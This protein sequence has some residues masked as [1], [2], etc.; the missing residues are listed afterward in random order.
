MSSRKHRLVRGI[1]V[2]VLL[3]SVLA[4][5]HVQASPGW[6][7][8]VKLIAADGVDND[9][10]GYSVSVY[11]DTLVAGAPTDDYLRG[12]AYV[13]ARDLGS[14]STWGQ[15]KKLLAPDG[16]GGPYG[17][18]F[19]RSVGIW[20]DTIVV[21]AVWDD[22]G[23]NSN[24][25]SAYVFNRNQDGTNNW[26]LVRKLVPSDGASGDFFGSSVAIYGDTVVV[27]AE[28]YPWS[29]TDTPCAYVFDRNKDGPNQWG[30]V[31]KLTASDGVSVYWFGSSVAISGDTVVVGAFGYNREGGA[32]YVFY[33]DLGGEDNW[34]ELKK[35]VAS[36]GGG[37][38]GYS[39]AISGDI[40]VAGAP[41]ARPGGYWH[42][43]G[44][45]YVFYRDHGGANNW[46]E[47]KKLTAADGAQWDSLGKSVAIDGDVVLAGAHRGAPGVAYTFARN[48]GGSDNWGQV[49]RVG[50]PD[51]A[52][53]DSFGFAVAMAG[54]T[55]VVGAYGMDSNRG[56]VYVG[57]YTSPPPP[58]C[59]E[60]PSGMVSWWPG[61]GNA[62]DIAGPNH[63][64]LY[65]GATF[66]PGKV[67]QAFVL[68]GVD[69]YVA[70]PTVGVPAGTDA[71]TLELW[72]RMDAVVAAEAFFAGY[73]AFYDAGSYRGYTF[74]L[75]ASGT[76][77][78]FSTM[79]VMLMGPSLDLGRW[80]H[81][82]VTCVRPV[83]SGSIVTLWLNGQTVAEY[84]WGLAHL[85]TTP[86]TTFYIGRIPGWPGD[87]RRLQGAVD[88]LTVYDRALSGDE[89]LATFIAGSHGKCSNEAPVVNA[90]P[91]VTANEGMAF[92]SEG[93][94]SDP[95]PDTWTATVD[96]G[97]GSG[98]QPLGLVD[99]SF[100]LSHVYADDGTYTVLVTVDDGQGGVGTDTATVAVLNVAPTIELSGDASVDEGS[101]YTLTLGPVTDPGADTVELYIVH[102]GDG[103]TN[104]YGSQ[105]NVQ[106][107]Y[108]DGDASHTIRVDLVDE[109]GTHVG[110]GT[111]SV[112]VLNVAPA[113]G[114]INAPVD[115]VQLGTEIVASAAFVD[116]GTLD[117]HTALW[118]WG[119]G[120]TSDGTVT[121][122]GGSG[123]V[124]GSHTY[125]VPGIY[126]LHLT[127]T[128]N[129]GASGTAEFH[130][131]V[132]YNPE[133]GFVTGGGWIKSPAGAYVADASLV[134]KANFG[135]VSKYQ[136]GATI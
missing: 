7:G 89:I 108:A 24:Q 29:P 37:Y 10:L 45:A 99:K 71:R 63:G 53:A 13:F 34:G 93:S 51:G 75:G 52:A 4:A 3:I 41:C 92:S 83:A 132:V 87:T 131:I 26:G 17:D 128:D 5:L 109:D 62:W 115:P 66:A 135:F 112:T 122:P 95:D 84:E 35:L 127:V 85:N 65:N 116:P 136:K 103:H 90:G 59:L 31:K 100:T 32:A 102:W 111:L 104:T 38:L 129:D 74:H 105:G 110:A 44:A 1:L 19:G 64:V 97:D 78:I 42:C 18:S 79:S 76:R 36:D 46:G 125:T 118:D 9:E 27:G 28:L 86:G 43:V 6:T 134:G 107:T 96:Y 23:S 114:T 56:A 20:G 80:Y 47:I 69:G 57:P 14:P 130:Y 61:E 50:A 72:V 54:G 15:V 77:L 2:T 101:E 106:H 121:E 49:E 22:V 81:V 25:G 73:G 60:P 55:L 88:E 123:S 113:V 48:H 11:G 94:F 82:A 16:V 68:D 39:V 133:G 91:D 33:R 98:P 12:A 40:I 70:F 117:T 120:S 21:G 58:A 126:T 119:D 8:A 124:T 67:G 30:Q